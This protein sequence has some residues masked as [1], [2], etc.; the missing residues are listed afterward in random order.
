VVYAKTDYQVH[1]HATDSTS[2]DRKSAIPSMVDHYKIG[3]LDVAAIHKTSCIVD[4]QGINKHQMLDILT[5]TNEVF[6]I[7]YQYSCTGNGVSVQLA[8][9][10]NSASNLAMASGASFQPSLAK[11]IAMP[12]CVTVTLLHWTAYGISMV[13]SLVLTVNLPTISRIT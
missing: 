13:L 8:W 1:L 7:A 12:L 2:A 9:Y 5:A 4:L 3:E 10:K 11:N 6:A